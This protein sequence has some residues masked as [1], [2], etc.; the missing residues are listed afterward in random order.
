MIVVCPDC[1]KRFSAQPNWHDYEILVAKLCGGTIE[2]SGKS[3]RDVTGPDGIRYQVKMAN[4][5][6]DQWVW[7]GRF[8]NDGS[9]FYIL[10]R[11]DYDGSDYMYILPEKKWHILGKVDRSSDFRLVIRRKTLYKISE[12][13]CEINEDQFRARVRYLC[14]SRDH[15][16][17]KCVSF[18][19][20]FDVDN[21]AT[22]GNTA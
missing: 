11:V 1:G 19:M 2:S 16:F 14:G 7:F 6:Q 20:M 5:R 21:F 18:Q 22:K 12:F 17:L 15:N 3:G 8:P 4:I 10:F 9:D 13:Q